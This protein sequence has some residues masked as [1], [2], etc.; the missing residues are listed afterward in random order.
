MEFKTL[1]T[2]PLRCLRFYW[3]T[4]TFMKN[5][6]PSMMY[7]EITE[8]P[9]YWYMHLSTHLSNIFLSS[10]CI[11]ILF[12]FSFTTYSDI[13]GKFSTSAL[14]CNWLPPSILIKWRVSQ[15]KTKKRAG[16]S[17]KILERHFLHQ[18]KI[19]TIY[20]AMEN[21]SNPIVSRKW[22]S[23]WIFWASKLTWRGDK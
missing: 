23:Q 21:F 6:L 13:G 9:Q 20:M 16:S 3:P 12:Y 7:K 4:K 14:F 1:L 2:V 5:F 19:F 22:T 17:L 15:H 10:L 18:W 8:V 11:R